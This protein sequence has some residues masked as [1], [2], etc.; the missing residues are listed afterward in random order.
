MATARLDRG[1]VRRHS[2]LQPLLLCLLLTT[3]YCSAFILR[4]DFDGLAQGLQ[5]LRS[6][7]FWV[8][9]LKFIVVYRLA[10]FRDWTDHVSC[11]R[12]FR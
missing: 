7:W 3:S 9:V 2:L 10:S 4:Y 8:L 5:L 12:A 11:M 1:F 6:T